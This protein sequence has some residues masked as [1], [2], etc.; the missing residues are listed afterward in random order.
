[1]TD[2]ES[3][4]HAVPSVEHDAQSSRRYKENW[5]DAVQASKADAAEIAELKEAYALLF[6]AHGIERARWEDPTSVDCASC[7]HVAPVTAGVCVGCRREDVNAVLRELQDRTNQTWLVK[8]KRWALLVLRQSEEID[9]LRSALGKARDGLAGGLWD[10][11][12]GQD[13][14]EQC[15]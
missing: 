4:A 6:K 10:Y 2:K 12:P 1:M 5:D 15:N 14:H 9:R 7:A 11:G 13:E 8:R 3:F